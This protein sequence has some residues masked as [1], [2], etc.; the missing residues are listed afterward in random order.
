MS[1]T[2]DDDFAPREVF[3]SVREVE[4]HAKTPPPAGAGHTTLPMQFVGVFFFFYRV[5]SRNE[6][7]VKSSFR[8]SQRTRCAASCRHI[9][10]LIKNKIYYCVHYDIS[11]NGARL[12]LETCC[13]FVGAT[14]IAHRRRRTGRK[15]STKP[16]TSTSP[17]RESRGYE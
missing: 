13:F 14:T 2:T 5:V 6:R 8:D 17:T 10:A 11:L 15:R 4:C 3:V 1:F 9:A 16:L 7:R 12:V